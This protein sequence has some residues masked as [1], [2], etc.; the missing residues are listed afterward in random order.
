MHK[1][2]VDSDRLSRALL[3][4]SHECIAMLRA[5]GTTVYQSPPIERQLG[6][7]AEELTGRDNFDLVHEDDLADARRRFQATLA[8]ERC[9]A[10]LRLRVRHKDLSW[11]MLDVSASRFADDAGQA[12]VLLITRDV[13]EV[14]RQRRARRESERRLQLALDIAAIG[15][16]EY[17]P[18]AGRV[19][20]SDSVGL[21]LGDAS[22]ATQSTLD[23]L[24]A[25]VHEDDRARV[26]ETFAVT[27][28]AD[29]PADDVSFRVV[30][31]DGTERWWAARFRVMTEGQTPVR[32]V[33]VVSDV[34]TRKRQDEQRGQAQALEAVGHVTGGIAHDFKNLLTVITGY[35]ETLLS[36]LE[37]NDPRS[38]D[39]AE[40]LRA[41]ERAA[42]LTKQLAAVSPP[43]DARVEIVDANAIVSDMAAMISRLIGRQIELRVDVAPG[44]AAVVADRS[45]IEQVVMN[46]AVNARE[47][48]PFGGLL[49]I[50]TELVTLSAQQALA[51]GPLS[52]GDTV[53]LTVRDT[54]KT[55]RDSRRDATDAPRRDATD[56]PRRGATDTSAE[57]HVQAKATGGLAAAYAIVR[58]CGGH[59]A[60]ESSP[61]GGSTFSVYFPF[62]KAPL[63]EPSAAV[64][65]TDPG[66]CGTILIVAEDRTTREL[67]WGALTREGYRALS[68]ESGAQAL[69]LCR[70]FM[71]RL[72]LVVADWTMTAMSG[73]ELLDRIGIMRPGMAALYLSSGGLD[74][75][76]LPGGS[77]A[78]AAIIEKPFTSGSL[79]RRVRDLLTHSAARHLA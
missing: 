47:A 7:T 4:H 39:I 68:A 1:T 46:L 37:P 36:S 31:A 60:L 74:L 45:Q 34:T 69:K 66:S 21:L 70:D 29:R 78:Q 8:G 10:P 20:Y 62:S 15:F 12:F 40:I 26:A 25:R 61:G 54:G 59:V 14:V 18:A 23:W 24:L 77:D 43:E 65:E 2:D 79:L 41:S 49:E 6:F 64:G 48:M 72:D 27:S 38:G 50:R 53:L 11:R 35:S 42:T 67:V 63:P 32:V 71:G 75:P 51:L 16:V 5:D 22:A 17:E 13:T 57:P 3:R 55:R 76:S 19:T 56:A 30:R 52:A 44:T 28:D 73:P 9:A 33:V 58:Q